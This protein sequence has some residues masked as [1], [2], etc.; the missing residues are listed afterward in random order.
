[1][2]LTNSHGRDKNV[3]FFRKKIKNFFQR[4]KQR[5]GIILTAV[6][7]LSEVSLNEF[8]YNIESARNLSIALATPAFITA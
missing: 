7:Y 8:T 5:P 4:K 3:T 2:P 1:M 6:L